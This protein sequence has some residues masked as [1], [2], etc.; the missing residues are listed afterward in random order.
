MH[1]TRC[2]YDFPVENPRNFVELN[3]V[4]CYN[5]KIFAG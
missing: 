4:L 2:F 3:F 1:K 5:P